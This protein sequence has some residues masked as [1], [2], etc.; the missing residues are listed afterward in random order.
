MDSVGTYDNGNETSH[1]WM[2]SERWS[3]MARIWLNKSIY[4][5]FEFH[6][7]ML[8][9]FVPTVHLECAFKR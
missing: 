8:Q 3:K 4:S 9:I 7:K 1:V 6:L 2:Y 5:A